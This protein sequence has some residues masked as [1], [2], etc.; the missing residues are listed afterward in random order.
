MPEDKYKKRLENIVTNKQDSSTTKKTTTRYKLRDGSY[1]NSL[2][3][4]RGD[5]QSAP[6][7]GDYD[8]KTDKVS[9]GPIM[10]RSSVEKVVREEKTPN[11]TGVK[12][13]RISVPRKY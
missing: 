2:N 9:E 4:Y 13:K 12:A 5:V 1:T 7:R 10:K 3:T 11:A 6:Q 8:S